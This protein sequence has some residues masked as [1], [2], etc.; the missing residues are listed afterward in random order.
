M[1]KSL[2]LVLLR[3]L[4]ADA[5]FRV[6]FARRACH[7][8][9]DATTRLLRFDYQFL[10]YVTSLALPFD[11]RELKRRVPSCCPIDAACS[12]MRRSLEA[13]V[14]PNCGTPEVRFLRSPPLYTT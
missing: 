3:E 7:Y 9:F 2:C 14:S 6:W 13:V 10:P 12:C 5:G 4:D 8:A 1:Q 11:E